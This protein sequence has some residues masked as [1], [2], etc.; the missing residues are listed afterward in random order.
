MELLNQLFTLSVGVEPNKQTLQNLAQVFN[1][2][3]MTFRTSIL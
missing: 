1:G 3:S 2:A